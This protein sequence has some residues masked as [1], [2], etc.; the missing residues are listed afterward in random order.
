[1][2]IKNIFVSFLVIMIGWM[3]LT[4]SLDVSSVLLGTGISLALSVVLCG[5]CTLFNEINLTPKAF[6]YFFWYIIVF[7]IELVKANIDVTRRVLSPSMPINPGIVK[8]STTLKSK[9]ARLILANSITLTPGTFTIEITDDALY[10]H[11]IDVE[12]E[13]V[14]G[15]TNAI[16]RKFEKLLEVMYG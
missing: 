13:D 8:V 1:M 11:W 5:S 12:A 16:V 9:M 10:I 4:W 14:K 3:L 15:A 7:L 6:A 2:K